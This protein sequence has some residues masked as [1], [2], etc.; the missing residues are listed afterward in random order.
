MTLTEDDVERIVSAVETIE[1]SLAVLADRRFISTADL[2]RHDER[3]R[4][5]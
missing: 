2:S 1:Q 3:D 4:T 5:Y